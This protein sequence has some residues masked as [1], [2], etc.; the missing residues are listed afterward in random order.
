[1]FT[2]CS[3]NVH[4]VCTECALNVHWMLTE[5]SLNAHWR[6]TERALNVHWRCSLNVHWMF[7]ECSLKFV[8]WIFTK[9]S[10]KVHWIFTEGSLKVSLK[11]H[12]MFTEY[13]SWWRNSVLYKN[14]VLQ[15]TPPGMLGTGRPVTMIMT[16]IEV[17]PTV[18]MGCPTGFL[19]H[20]CYN[21][22][23]NCLHGVYS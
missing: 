14:M 2:E 1:M 22:E 10:L 20:L 11:F 16:D 4:W 21:D 3:L 18:H 15:R 12:L 17:C 19:I 8:H 13:Y 23:T 5:G 7:T 9:G 6:F